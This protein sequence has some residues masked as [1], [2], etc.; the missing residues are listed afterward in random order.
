MDDRDKLIL[1]GLFLSKFDQEGLR[2]LGFASFRE[3]FN[4]MALSV[5][6]RPASLKNYRDEF[7]P[8][9]DNARKG[10]HKRPMRDYCRRVFDLFGELPLEPFAAKLKTELSS[11][12]EVELVEEEL[13]VAE[14]SSF[15]RRMLTGQAAEAYFKDVGAA[16][17]PFDGYELEDATW[18][19]CG[20]DFKLSRGERD[21]FLA[22]E[23]K[24]MLEAAGPIR[25]TDKEYRVAKLLRERY[26]LF[27]VRNFAERPSH[28]VFR[29]PL[30]CGLD[31][32]RR[33]AVRTTVS[34]TASVGG[35]R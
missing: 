15:A 8:Y 26:F 9:H 5:N 30:H 6:A 7:D 25:M 10:W 35:P 21:P 31:F 24:G 19:G 2:V 13:D 12:G 20:F 18:M 23:V 3:A 11:L 28:V 22:V 1:A 33:E 29:D 14:E 16:T 32:E 34:W 27:V 4:T 17:P